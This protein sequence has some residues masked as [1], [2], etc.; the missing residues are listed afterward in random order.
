M[1][2]NKRLELLQERPYEAPAAHL[3]SLEVE[4]TLAK[5]NTETIDEDDEEY[6]WGV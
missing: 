1:N 2:L 4:D 6:D 5:S 3:Y